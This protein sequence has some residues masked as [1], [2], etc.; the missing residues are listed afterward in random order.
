ME[1]F[2]EVGRLSIATDELADL[3]SLFQ[4]MWMS[5]EAISGYISDVA[6]EGIMID[7]HTA[8][9]LA[10][11]RTR[12]PHPGVPFVAVATAHPAKFPDT[13][14][15]ATGKRPALP[16]HMGNLFDKKEHYDVLP[17]DLEIVKAFIR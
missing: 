12:H 4:S 5:D 13:V 8:I 10:G 2:R 9:G 6:K 1:G 16:G 17:A 14:E 7:P 3:N 15:A 11:A